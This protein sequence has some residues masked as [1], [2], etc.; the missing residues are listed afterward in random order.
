MSKA[1]QHKL[2]KRIHQHLTTGETSS[3]RTVSP[4]VH[5][6]F[7][8]LMLLGGIVYLIEVNETSTQGFKIHTL[9]RQ[10]EQL[11]GIQREL[12]MRQAEA[13]S[14]SLLKEKA[15][16]MELVSVEKVE[17]LSGDGPLALGR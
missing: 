9:E 2:L 6:A 14:L 8:V 11:Q 16:T 15:K 12:E 4:F 3:G 13:D 1:K 7:A 10:V 17:T 5:I